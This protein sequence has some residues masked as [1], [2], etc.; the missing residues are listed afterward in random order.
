MNT[1]SFSLVQFPLLLILAVAIVS[2][3]RSR[4]IPNWLTGPAALLGLGLHTVLDRIDGLVFSIEGIAVGLGLFLVLYVLGWM[5]AGDAKLYASVGS[6][7]GPIQTLSAAVLIAMAGGLLT[8]LAL[9]IHQGWKKTGAW[10]WDLIQMLFL[11]RSLKPVA[12]ANNTL[13]LPYA[14]AISIGTVWSFWWSP[15]G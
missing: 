5:G 14:V 12:A 15:L 7:L 4:K 13:K 1:M 2:D 9:G 11:T 10:L 3:L 8:I 6:F